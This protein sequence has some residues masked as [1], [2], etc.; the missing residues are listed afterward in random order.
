MRGSVL[1]RRVH[2]V[3]RR[4]HTPASKRVPRLP[5]AARGGSSL[6]LWR[7][8]PVG[9]KLLIPYV[10]LLV[11]FPHDPY[12]FQ[13]VLWKIMFGEG[14]APLRPG[15]LVQLHLFPA[16]VETLG[17]P[18]QELRR[19]Q[20]V[21][22]VEERLALHAFGPRPEYPVRP[23][24]LRLGQFQANHHVRVF[25]ALIH[26]LLV[27]LF[28]DRAQD[29]DHLARAVRNQ[30]ESEGLDLGLAAVQ[31][32][33]HGERGAADLRGPAARGEGEKIPPRLRSDPTR[34][35]RLLEGVGR[36]EALVTVLGDRQRGRPHPEDFVPARR[37]DVEAFG[38]GRL[39]QL[40]LYRRYHLE[41]LVRNVV[42]TRQQGGGAVVREAEKDRVRRRRL[43]PPRADD[44][45]GAS[46][47]GVRLT[48]GFP[49]GRRAYEHER[50]DTAGQSHPL[51]PPLP[52]V[53]ESN[54]EAR[55]TDLDWE[56]IATFAAT[57]G[58]LTPGITRRDT[59]GRPSKLTM[60][61]T[62]I[63]VGCMPLLGRAL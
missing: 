36:R 22:V 10:Q 13:R 34:G 27:K 29:R 62:L 37:D 54:L 9:G 60:R 3:V 44:V 46:L 28:R 51:D 8:P 26:K 33:P 30:V 35:A 31:F 52:R 16:L 15:E 45:K 17:R 4:A 24:I 57:D 11:L 18:A 1:G 21:V 5:P 61:G 55:P 50:T 40:I 56:A 14:L 48:E 63:P 2:A 42:G 12:V 25:A 39:V 58:G 20:I 6:A 47:R 38:R 19:V 41:V 43:R 53:R 59:T 32:S 7:R 23:F 49:A